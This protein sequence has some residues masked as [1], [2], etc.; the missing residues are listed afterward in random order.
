MLLLL[1]ILGPQQLVW[2]PYALILYNLR[3]LLS[4]AYLLSGF[5]VHSGQK[6]EVSLQHLTVTHGSIFLSCWP[7]SPCI[8]DLG[9][10]P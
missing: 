8:T 1:A 7:D 2:D 4:A 3:T 9:L 6:G 10:H 5:A